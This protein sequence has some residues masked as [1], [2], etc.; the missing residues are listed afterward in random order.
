M[1]V[2]GVSEAGLTGT[3]VSHLETLWVWASDLTPP[4]L[5]FLIRE[6]SIW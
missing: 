4:C 1:K 2:R 5:S 6:G 3:L